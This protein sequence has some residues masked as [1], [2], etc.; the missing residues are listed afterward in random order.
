MSTPRRR[1]HAPT[2]ARA[3]TQARAMPRASAPQHRL[4]SGRLPIRF[5]TRA[6]SRTQAAVLKITCAPGRLPYPPLPSGL[7][8]QEIS[9]CVGAL[10]RLGVR[11][12]RHVPALL[13]LSAGRLGSFRNQELLHL[14]WAAARLGYVP[15]EDWLGE[16]TDETYDR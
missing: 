13:A 5:T 1:A 4:Q 16:F 7:G 10:A 9:C 2:P 3:S 15:H 12:P 8:G 11:H 6:H 14:G